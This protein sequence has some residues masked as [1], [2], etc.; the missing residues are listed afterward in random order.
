MDVEH[1]LVLYHTLYPFGGPPAVFAFVS[2]L[3]H[4]VP[5]VSGG[6]IYHTQSIYPIGRVVKGYWEIGR[7][8][9][10]PENLGG[11]N[12]QIPGAAEEAPTRDSMIH[13][14]LS[15]KEMGCQAQAPA[16]GQ[17]SSRQS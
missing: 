2:I 8:R 17:P 4:L 3:R 13:A 15:V 12:Q 9:K 14:T 16:A 7:Q 10:A 6:L 1:Y 5:P 11:T